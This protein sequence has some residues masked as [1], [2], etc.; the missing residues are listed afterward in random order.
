MTAQKGTAYN[1]ALWGEEI[2]MD[3]DWGDSLTWV[4]ICVT[5]RYTTLKIYVFYVNCT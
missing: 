3:F 4:Y 5:T 2:D 1:E